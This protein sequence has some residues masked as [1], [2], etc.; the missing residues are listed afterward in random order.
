MLESL[1]DI[2]REEVATAPSGKP[3]KTEEPSAGHPE[4]ELSRD[5]QK[6]EKDAPSSLEE[7]DNLSDALV[8]ES[9]EEEEVSH[10]PPGGD[11]PSQS[12][13]S[14]TKDKTAFNT[15]EEPDPSLDADGA[16]EWP[17]PRLLKLSEKA[18]SDAKPG[19]SETS[20]EMS[21]GTG[22]EELSKD[23]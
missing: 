2:E 14:N 10:G 17:E 7:T 6:E 8:E 19:N 15:Q 5:S 23:S 4:S 12:E 9:E 16:E 21:A 11:L 1:E 20:K 18:T 13:D 3:T 22:E